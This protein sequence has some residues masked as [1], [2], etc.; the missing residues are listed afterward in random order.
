[1]T[2][3][4]ASLRH[5]IIT[6][7]GQRINSMEHTDGKGKPRTVKL[8]TSSSQFLHYIQKIG[9]LR[10]FCESVILFHLVRVY[11]S[12]CTFMMLTNSVKIDLRLEIFL[13][14]CFIKRTQHK[15]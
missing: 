9:L 4:F 11:F 1:M 12:M 5:R 8:K 7:I 2:A 6:I 15:P 13:L 14:Y 3:E 10:I